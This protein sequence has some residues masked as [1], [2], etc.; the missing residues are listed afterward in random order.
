MGVLFWANPTA[1]ASTPAASA[2]N[3]TCLLGIVCVSSRVT[4]TLER[5]RQ[6]SICFSCNNRV[7]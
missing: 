3:I 2:A 5:V 1:P 7:T 4:A 6:T